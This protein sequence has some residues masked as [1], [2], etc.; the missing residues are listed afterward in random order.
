MTVLILVVWVLAVA[1]VTRLLTR[2]K[3]TEP[4]RAW[5]LDRRGADSQVAYLVH[6]AWCSSVW[7][8]FASAPA[9]VAAAGLSWW[10]LPV[11]A[12]AGSHVVGMLSWLDTE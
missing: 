5:V 12:L 1:R 6:C 7:I 9:A 4:F 2:D 3:L 8:G 11:I 10:L